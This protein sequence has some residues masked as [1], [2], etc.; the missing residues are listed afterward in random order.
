MHMLSGISVQSLFHYSGT[1]MRHNIISNS[2]HLLTCQCSFLID[3]AKYEA[4]LMR[5]N[6]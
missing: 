2:F 3:D 6:V 5:K 4:E 1:G